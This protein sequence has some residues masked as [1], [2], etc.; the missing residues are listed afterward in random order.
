MREGE[1]RDLSNLFPLSSTSTKSCGK[2]ISPPIIH[3][4][5]PTHSL[6]K[7]LCL[8]LTAFAE[9]GSAWEEGAGAEAG[10][11]VWGGDSSPALL[12]SSTGLGGSASS[13]G[14]GWISKNSLSRATKLGGFLP[15]G[16]SSL[17]TGC[18]A[19]WGKLCS[20]HKPPWL[21]RVSHTSIISL[22]EKRNAEQP[23][24]HRAGVSASV[25]HLLHSH[26]CSL[27]TAPDLN[28]QP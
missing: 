1:D 22:L 15:P 25:P 13:V 5:H 27:S 21:S 16:C 7:F 26:L 6:Q 17:S 24:E 14:S 23:G 28:L 20:P 4:W 3:P 19:G 8:P 2:E 9:S 18:R 10:M 12:L 11:W